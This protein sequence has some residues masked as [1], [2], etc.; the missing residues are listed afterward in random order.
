MFPS[1]FVRLVLSRV[2][3]LP[4]LGLLLVLNLLQRLVRR[5]AG[6]GHSVFDARQAR[7]GPSEPVHHRQ[8]Q[9]RLPRRLRLPADPGHRRRRQN[10][11]LPQRHRGHRCRQVITRL[12]RRHACR[13]H[14]KG[15]LVR[16]GFVANDRV[17][18]HRGR[19]A[20]GHTV[21]LQLHQH[22]PL[23][24]RRA[25]SD[26][27]RARGRLRPAVLPGLCQVTAFIRLDTPC[28]CQVCW[29][30]WRGWPT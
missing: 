1:T 17:L 27:H 4:P 23:V 10:R 25:R 6:I 7:V 19:A 8:R 28:I 24:A 26:V 30:H 15:K 5:G 29:C 16:P 22:Q 20:T 21:A 3:V 2:A 9:V 14:G 18:L 11:G 13:I 12:H